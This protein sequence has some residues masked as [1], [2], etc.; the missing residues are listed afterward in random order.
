MESFAEFGAGGTEFGWPDPWITI[1][2]DQIGP[3]PTSAN[4]SAAV[5]LLLLDHINDV[6]AP[7]WSWL[8]DLGM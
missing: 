4:T 2:V 8:W 6:Y 1:R 5:Q 3:L 7:A